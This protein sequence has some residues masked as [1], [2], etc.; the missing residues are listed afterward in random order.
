MATGRGHGIPTAGLDSRLWFTASSLGAGKRCS[1]CAAG[2]RDDTMASI[3]GT[4]AT[5]QR[6]SPCIT[7]SPGTSMTSH[8][9]LP[10]LRG[11]G[12]TSQHLHYVIS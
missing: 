8:P 12:V 10:V 11:N 4:M 6:H 5:E 7:G 2:F 1:E 9:L 3:T